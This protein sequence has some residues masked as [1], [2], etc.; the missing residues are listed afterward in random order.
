[1][2]ET[3]WPRWEVFKQDT[4][5]KPHQAVG[6]VHAPDAETALLTARNVFVRRPK[7]VSL[8]IAPAEAILSV[9]REELANGI[10]NADEHSLSAT[11][12]VFNKTSQ[13]RS[14]TFV[15]YVGEVTATS[16]Y[17]A[18]QVAIAQ[19]GDDGVWVWWIVPQDEIIESA[20]TDIASWFAPAKDK[21]YRQQ[22]AYG[23]VSPR[24]K[25]RTE[26]NA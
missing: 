13:R 15:D 16:A 14:M 12:F 4:P 8:W 9:T 2:N 23:F 21:K 3:Q 5:R 1:M 6:S 19:F 22:S 26:S 20:E 17:D 7:A 25:G 10:E 24:R 18:L 11:Y